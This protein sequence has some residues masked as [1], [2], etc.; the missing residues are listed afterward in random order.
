MSEYHLIPT[1]YPRSRRQ[2]RQGSIEWLPSRK[3][4]GWVEL[5][6]K[7]VQ[8]TYYDDHGKFHSDT[9]YYKGIL[10]PTRRR[11]TPGYIRQRTSAA[12]VQ[13]RCNY[14]KKILENPRSPRENKEAVLQFIIDNPDYFT[15]VY[16]GD[17]N[18]DYGRWAKIYNGGAKDVSFVQEMIRKYRGNIR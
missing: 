3:P 17:P 16:E 7:N 5:G 1:R 13:Q 10:G 8:K 11:V 9:T 6:P 15:P 2:T 18:T 14:C 12:S 4:E